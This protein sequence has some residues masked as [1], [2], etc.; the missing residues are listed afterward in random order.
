M[1]VTGSDSH[2]EKIVGRMKASVDRGLWRLSQ[3]S[4][5]V[6][7]T[8]CPQE[9]A[10]PGSGHIPDTVCVCACVRVCVR[11]CACVCVCVRVCVVGYEMQ[12]GEVEVPVGG[13]C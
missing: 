11:V 3:E 6:T 10:P 12:T 9:E 1:R 4:I 8:F 2:F 13:N 7:A 5:K